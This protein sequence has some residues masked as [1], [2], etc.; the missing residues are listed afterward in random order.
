MWPEGTA[1]D[2]Q[3]IM[4]LKGMKRAEQMQVLETLGLD[5]SG[6]AAANIDGT[7]PGT[8][9]STGS[10]GLN[11]AGISFQTSG[12]SLSGASVPLP[13]VGKML[14]PAAKMTVDNTR[15]IA[16]KVS[17]CQN[18]CFLCNVYLCNGL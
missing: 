14:Q 13:Q 15:E 4:T 17:N 5:T 2:L 16:S 11:V 8:S 7:L 1:P 9:S 3:A 10:S 12:V 6:A 18:D